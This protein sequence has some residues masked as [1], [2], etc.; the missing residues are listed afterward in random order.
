MAAGLPEHAANV[1]QPG[2]SRPPYAFFEQPVS[3]RVLHAPRGLPVL[4]RLGAPLTGGI[5]GGPLPFCACTTFAGN[6]TLFIVCQHVSLLRAES[7]HGPWTRVCDLSIVT[8]GGDGGVPGTWSTFKSPQRERERGRGDHLPSALTTLD[9]TAC[10]QRTC[11]CH[12]VPTWFRF[13][14]SSQRGRKRALLTG[15]AAHSRVLAG[16]SLAPQLLLLTPLATRDGCVPCLFSLESTGCSRAAVRRCVGW[17][18]VSFVDWWCAVPVN[19]RTQP[20]LW[21]DGRSNWHVLCHVYTTNDGN[22][23][24]LAPAS[25]P[26]SP[27]T[28]LALMESSGTPPLCHRVGNRLS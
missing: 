26:S 14:E 2:S 12:H 18:W 20:F 16:A 6:G 4:V 3:D 1:R 13:H 19:T 21:Q 24:D 10:A 22:T 5:F 9:T 17:S 27:A 11:V 8:N 7:V 25:T 23:A 28:S 15:C